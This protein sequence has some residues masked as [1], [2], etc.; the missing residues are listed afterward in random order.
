VREEVDASSVRSKTLG[1]ILVA[2]GKLTPEQVQQVVSHQQ[3]QGIAFGEAA[4]AM[5][6]VSNEDVLQA[7]SRQYDF[8]L[9]QPGENVIAA[10]LVAAYRPFSVVGEN[11][12]ALRAQLA[13]RWF[14]ADPLKRVLA[15]VSPASG[16]G[17]SFMAANLAVAFSQQGKKTLLIDANM[18]NPR[19]Q[20]IFGLQRGPGLSSVLAERVSLGSAIEGVEGIPDLHLL[21]A[22][23]QPPNP[24]E[25]LGKPAWAKTLIFASSNFDVV[26]IDTPDGNNYSDASLIALQARGALVVIR[27]DVSLLAETNKFCKGLQDMGVHLV[28]SM[29]NDV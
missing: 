3:Q 10:E 1:D 29:L 15:I 11:I 28:G 6:L 23:P 25:L 22:G 14:G 4:L 12:R 17:K 21:T 27:K 26:I 16:E 5:K 20:K 7:L 19:L 8:A 13:V 9:L 2:S 24:A 18:R